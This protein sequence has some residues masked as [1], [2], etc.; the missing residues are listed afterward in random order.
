MNKP[1]FIDP[2]LQRHF[3]IRSAQE[4]TEHARLKGREKEE[5]I[6]VERLEADATKQLSWLSEREERLEPKAPFDLKM[7]SMECADAF[8][9]E[10]EHLEG[11]TYSRTLPRFAE[12]L[13]KAI[14]FMKG[15]GF[16]IEDID[17]T[18]FQQAAE[19]AQEIDDRLIHSDNMDTLSIRNYAS[20]L[21][22]KC[23]GLKSGE[24]L[25]LPGGWAGRPSGHA[26]LFRLQRQPDNSYAFTIFNT[27]AGLNYHDSII[28][29]GEEKFQTYLEIVDISHKK[30]LSPEFFQLFLELN[31]LPL[32]KGNATASEKNIYQGMINYLNGKQL[33]GKNPIDF[34]EFYMQAQRSGSCAMKSIFAMLHQAILNPDGVKKLSTEEM[35]QR[36]ELYKTIKFFYKRE[37]LLDMCRAYLSSG[38]YDRTTERLISQVAAQWVRTAN[39]L[40][41]EGLNPYCKGG[42]PILTAELLQ[43]VEATARDIK[44]KLSLHKMHYKQ[45]APTPSLSLELAERDFIQSEPCQLPILSNGQKNTVNSAAKPKKEQ[46]SP[47]LSGSPSDPKQVNA[48][49]SN[50]LASLERGGLKRGSLQYDDLLVRAIRRL[51]I[52]HRGEDFWSELDAEEILPCMKMLSDLSKKCFSKTASP[53][54]FIASN[55]LLAIADKLARRLPESKLKEED[56]VSHYELVTFFHS[57]HIQLEHPEDQARTMELLYYFAPDFDPSDRPVKSVHP[58]DKPYRALE[59]KRKKCLFALSLNNRIKS[60]SQARVLKTP[61]LSYLARF[62]KGEEAERMLKAEFAG[63]KPLHEQVGLLLLETPENAKFLPPSVH[64]LRQ[65]S[66]GAQYLGKGGLPENEVVFFTHNKILGGKEGDQYSLSVILKYG[67]ELCQNGRGNGDN[68]IDQAFKNW[69]RFSSN[70]ENDQHFYNEEQNRVMANFAEEKE[71]EIRLTDID[72]EDEVVRTLTYFMSLS[73]EELEKMGEQISLFKHLFRPGRLQPLIKNEPRLAVKLLNFVNNYFHHYVGMEKQQPALFFG[74]LGYRLS[75]QI[76][77]LWKENPQLFSGEVEKKLREIETDYRKAIIE[78]IRP[79]AK[80]TMELYQVYHYLS[81]ICSFFELGE[82]KLN[83]EEIAVDLFSWEILSEIALMEDPME[84]LKIWD[85]SVNHFDRFQKRILPELTHLLASNAPMRYRVLTQL[86][87]NIVKGSQEELAGLK[88]DERCRFPLFETVDGKYKIDLKNHTV[89]V[90]GK[91]IAA[92][93]RTIVEMDSFKQIFSDIKEVRALNENHTLFEIVDSHGVSRIDTS[94]SL[95]IERQFGAVEFDESAPSYTY[96]PQS[97]L[98]LP[99]ENIPCEI[100]KPNDSFVWYQ[101]DPWGYSS[102][103][104]YMV[105]SLSDDKKFYVMMKGCE[106]SKDSARIATVSDTLEGKRILVDHRKSQNMYCLKNIELGEHLFCWADSAHPDVISEIELPRLNLHFTTREKEGSLFAYCREVPG[107]YI[108]P[109]Q[110]I[111]YRG[112]EKSSLLLTNSAGEKKAIIPVGRFNSVIS[113]AKELYE[114]KLGHTIAEGSYF[115]VYDLK[116]EEGEFRLHPSSVSDALLLASQLFHRRRYRQVLHYLKHL[117]ALRAY[118]ELEKSMIES[119]IK[120][121][122]SHPSAIMLRL[123]LSVMLADNTQKYSTEKQ[124]P[125]TKELAKMYT[126]YLANRSNTTLDKLTIEEE[127]TILRRL[128]AAE[129]LV[130]PSIIDRLDCLLH[131]EK[132]QV[133]KGLQ[134]STKLDPADALSKMGVREICGYLQMDKASDPNEIRTSPLPIAFLSEEEFKELFPKLY[135]AARE[136]DKET[137]QY[138]KNVLQ[139]MEGNNLLSN[140]QSPLAIFSKAAGQNG[141]FIALAC[142]LK[143]VMDK[144]KNFPSREALLEHFAIVNSPYGNSFDKA[145]KFYNNIISNGENSRQ[146]GIIGVGLDL[147]KNLIKAWPF[148]NPKNEEALLSIDSLLVEN[149]PPEDFDEPLPIDSAIPKRDHEWDSFFETF[150]AEE[151]SYFTVEQIP[152]EKPVEME[153][154]GFGGKRGEMIDKLEKFYATLPESS[155]AFSFNEAETGRFLDALFSKLQREVKEY[156]DSHPELLQFLAKKNSELYNITRD[157]IEQQGSGLR[158]ALSPE[159]IARC[160]HTLKEAMHALLLLRQL[161]IEALVNEMPQDAPIETSLKQLGKEHKKLTLSDAIALFEIGSAESYSRITSMSDEQKAELDREVGL[162]GIDRTRCIQLEG[163]LAFLQKQCESSNGEKALLQQRLGEQLKI[164]RSHLS[165]NDSGRSRSYLRYEMKEGMILRPIQVEVLDDLLDRKEPLQLMEILGTGSGKTKVLSPMKQW[166]RRIKGQRLLINVWPS[167]HYPVNRED[168]RHQVVNNYGQRSDTSEFSRNMDTALDSL[169]FIFRELARGIGETRQINAT[170]ENLQSCELKFLE[171]LY[172][173]AVE[174]IQHPEG[175]IEIFR[176]I[177]NL[178]KKSEIHAD[179]AH[180][181]FSPKR[182]VNFTV[183]SPMM[184]DKK[185]VE[186]IGNIYKILVSGELDHYIRLKTNQQHLLSPKEIADVIAPAIAD[187]LAEYLGI[188]TKNQALFNEYREYVLNEEKGQPDWLKDHPKKQQIALLRGELAFSVLENCLAKSTSVHYGRS[189][190]DKTIEFAKP[191]DAN[192]SCVEKAEYD[193][194]AETLNKTFQIY[195]YERLQISQQWKLIQ[196]LRDQAKEECARKPIDFQMTNTEAYRFYIQHFPPAM[197]RKNLFSLTEKDLEDVRDEINAV[198]ELI[199]YYVENL[200]APQIK[201]YGYKLKSDP[202]NFRSMFTDIAT[203]TATPGAME[204]YGFTGDE[205]PID[206]ANDAEVLSTLNTK[207]TSNEQFGLLEAELPK[208]ILDEI[209]SSLNDADSDARMLIDIGA[210]FKGISNQAVAEAILA[211]CRGRLQGVA[212]YDENNHLMMLEEGGRLLPFDQSQLRPQERFTYC[213]NK[214]MFG[215]DTKQPPNAKGICTFDTHVDLDDMLQGVGRLREFLRDQTAKWVATKATMHAIDPEYSQN[216]SLYAVIRDHAIKNQ[217][218]READET[219]RSTKQQMRNEIRALCMRKILAADPKDVLPLFLQL[220]DILVDKVLNDPLS[221]YGDIQESVS[222]AKAL[223]TYRLG[224]MKKVEALQTSFTSDE[225]AEL[226]GKLEGFKEKIELLKDKLPKEVKEFNGEIGTESEIQVQIEIQKEIQTVSSSKE[227][228]HYRKPTEW[229]KDLDIFEGE[230]HA[231]A[232]VREVTGKVQ[233]TWFSYLGTFVSTFFKPTTMAIRSLKELAEA[234][235]FQESERFMIF[236]IVGPLASLVIAVNA[237]AFAIIC[238]PA[239]VGIIAAATVVETYKLLFLRNRVHQEVVQ[240]TIFG[241][242]AA[243]NCIKT[244]V[245]FYELGDVVKCHP[246]KEVSDAHEIFKDNEK[247]K[248]RL[249]NNLLRK[250]PEDSDDVTIKALGEEQKPIHEILVIEEEVDGEKR[251]TVI[252]GDQS[253]DARFFR[254][255]LRK[256]K[257][258]TSEEDAESR[259]RKICLFDL[260]LGIIQNGKNAID[261]KE[262]QN[263]K[264]F[265]EILVKLKLFNADTQYSEKEEEILI[266]LAKEK[267]DRAKLHKFLKCAI[268]HRDRK[269]SELSGSR[270]NRILGD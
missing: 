242:I 243:K 192:D 62:L 164:K 126:K 47:E 30:F 175:S 144:P 151:S 5:P 41:S 233:R 116:N 94:N 238:I 267:E 231:P 48:Y 235:F 92:L 154:E 69:E 72:A 224:L 166:L 128:Q 248:I 162:Y 21:A 155:E 114:P 227:G 22:E 110:D 103:G 141:K 108:D 132:Q 105:E 245:P 266:D 50:V 120:A 129:L 168:V 241:V 13:G 149:S 25:W 180:I 17:T 253:T 161:K 34:P 179:E 254:K 206:K 125:A 219:F 20:Q 232:S 239:F 113:S 76:D 2:N 152:V 195:L 148:Y 121:K 177:L 88:W 258:M 16:T 184:E 111:D 165:H 198:D 67:A 91:Q 140:E 82:G 207:C 46:R 124:A 225:Y 115:A 77:Y 183:G 210:L 32:A 73:K 96:I 58:R 8:I 181:N 169:K 80:T 90:N 86:I 217:E 38:K 204:A 75:Q 222:G 262:L 174:G 100:I 29:N 209:I 172:D 146:Q 7:F 137:K 57:H 236:S 188:D 163:A 214:H 133:K 55:T 54:L 51:P 246:D 106:E 37:S 74:K 10:T 171:L 118:T 28:V 265:Q 40:Y 252:A 24:S 268:V 185:N 98:E 237:I 83:F 66:Y 63:N 143:K 107:F 49:L 173:E 264:D 226:N 196:H 11:N 31:I 81:E 228:L 45:V 109:N 197:T 35:L 101:R 4:Y 194:T 256:D 203:M 139:L 15:Q 213:D 186:L 205:E 202:Q 78:E 153:N 123:R 102:R 212:F 43:R 158:G 255:A 61:Y 249:T 9:T 200:V 93:P 218:K 229:P 26:I 122:D 147:V 56:A 215:S 263:S 193:N 53:D 87:G 201:K 119:M 157:L 134:Q 261:E 189:K 260:K 240:P 3:E 270:V 220:K 60:D 68:P 130:V 191:Y 138:L 6:K 14:D 89:F 33:E 97:D 84:A 117:Y 71:R 23:S 136:G 250:V 112:K 176:K 27:G 145:A 199:F 127:K 156:S 65:I 59:K 1:L 99:L 44:E 251:Y 230:W 182:E 70:L 85:S 104:H 159:E 142:L 52:P 150:F 234:H 42:K 257:E 36:L 190:A 135:L 39:K 95:S 247:Q 244:A 12:T 259:K 178:M 208:E 170:P 223:E 187:K 18:P 216:P 167:Q 160:S 79:K 131:P 211:K 269:K 19:I 221:L 64:Y